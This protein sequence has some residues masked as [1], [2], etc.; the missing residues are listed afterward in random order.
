MSFKNIIGRTQG[1][2]HSAEGPYTSADAVVCVTDD[3]ADT[4]EIEIGFQLG[5]KREQVYLTVDAEELMLAILR[6]RSKA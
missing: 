6:V 3:G 4:G 5:D 2:K 1:W